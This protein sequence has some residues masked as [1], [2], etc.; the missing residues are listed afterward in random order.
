MHYSPTTRKTTKNDNQTKTWQTNKQTRNLIQTKTASLNTKQLVSDVWR[1]ARNLILNFTREQQQQHNVYFLYW[2][3]IETILNSSGQEGFGVHARVLAQE[4]IL[5]ANISWY[6]LWTFM[7]QTKADPVCRCKK[8]ISWTNNCDVTSNV[9]VK[10]LT[11]SAK[12]GRF[13]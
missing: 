13:S 9:T 3:N 6:F 1:S 12:H 5:G 10:R 11:F 8:I 7:N 2:D 4:I